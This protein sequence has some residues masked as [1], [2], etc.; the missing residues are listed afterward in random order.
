VKEPSEPNAAK[1]KAKKQNKE[2]KGCVLS[3][4]PGYHKFSQRTGYSSFKLIYIEKLRT[5]LLA[6]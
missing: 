2:E 3:K 5:I 6:L 4:P 1:G